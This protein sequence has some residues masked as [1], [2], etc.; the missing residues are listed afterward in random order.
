M[1]DAGKPPVDFPKS[2]Q[3]MTSRLR[4]VAPVLRAVGIEREDLPRV[5]REGARRF[6]LYSVCKTTSDTSVTSASHAIAGNHALDAD[7]PADELDWPRHPAR[8]ARQ[9]K[10][11]VID[12]SGGIADASDVTDVLIHTSGDGSGL[13]FDFEEEE[14]PF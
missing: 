14:V 7:V 11:G 8:L 1:P 13:A 4:R 5:G 9:Q 3:A 10:N 2:P 6:R 12:E